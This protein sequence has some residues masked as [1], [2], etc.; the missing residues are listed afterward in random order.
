MT[1]LA[2]TRPIAPGL[3]VN[4]DGTPRLVAGRCH[5]CQQPHFPEAATCPYCGGACEPTMVGPRGQLRLFTVVRRAPPGYLGPVP[6][7]FGVVALDECGLEVISRLTEADLTRLHPG[8]PMRL[9]IGP[10]YTDD[11]G[12]DVVSWAFAVHES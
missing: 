5:D 9:E 12:C 2:G 6:Y 4:D 3:F 7:G 1:A 8:L 10:L 11:D